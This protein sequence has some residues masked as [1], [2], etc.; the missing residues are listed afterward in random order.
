ME[1]LSYKGK[2]F[3]LGEKPFQ[4]ISGAIHYFR[5]V[6]EYW[7]DRLKKLKNCGFN[8]VET[9]MPWNLHEPY[10]GQFDFEGILDIDRF[11]AIAESLGLKVIVRPGPYI[12]AEWEFGGFPS[13]LLKNADMKLR[14]YYEP[15]L[16]KVKKYYTKVMEILKP[17]FSTRGGGIIAM[18]IENEYGSYGNDKKYL[19]YIQ[20]LMLDLDC[21]VMLFTSDGGLNWMLN[22]GTLP[23]VLKIANFGSGTKKN[24]EQLKKHQPNAPYM[25]GEFWNGWFDHWGEDHITRDKESVGEELEEILRQNGNVN[26][27]MFHGGTNFNFYNGSN[28][29]GGKIHPTVTS[30]D[31]DC[32]LS[33]NGNMTE[34]YYLVKDILKSHSFE[35]DMYDV[36]NLP[37]V[38]YEDIRLTKSAPL[39]ENLLGL[40]KAVKQAY[41]STMEEMGQSY[42]FILYRT[43]LSYEQEKRELYI[44][45]VHDRAMIF[46]NGELVGI[47]DRMGRNDRV[48]IEVKENETVVLDILVENLGR[49]NYGPFLKDRKGITE[50]ARLG[51]QT[52]NDWEIYNLPLTDLSKLEYSDIVSTDKP[53]F[54][55]GV[56]NIDGEPCDTFLD[57]ESFTKGV[58]FVNGEN[59]GR[60]WDI[61]PLKTVYIP[62]PILK[63]GEN[64]I[65]VFELHKLKNENIK[66]TDRLTQYEK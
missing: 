53:C 30:Y 27:Y 44:D 54:Y 45:D 3:Y 42:G 52:I 8:T 9:Y 32:L 41:T 51:L 38:K 61:G 16:E 29:D 63:K 62:A 37:C 43:Y 7:E 65:E 5:T 13:W 18:Q 33:E 35:T 17:H 36:K 10:E 11:I 64:I 34:K 48:E 59:M 22:G 4:I 6:P 24:F 2:Q 66:F 60:C 39:F 28:F 15:Y 58:I 26:F 31:Y 47:K 46:V 49:I 19:K 20:D 21:D 57:C 1:N 55:K 12:C 50:R 40:S 14:C 25:C 56:L 23:D